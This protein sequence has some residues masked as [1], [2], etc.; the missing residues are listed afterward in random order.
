MLRDG[1][2]GDGN[3]ET[4]GKDGHE[5]P[6]L[7]L[8]NYI[9]YDEMLVSALVGLSGPTVFINDGGRYSLSK[10]FS[11]RCYIFRKDLIQIEPS[12]D[13]LE[14]SRKREFTPLLLVPGR[15]FSVI[16][17]AFSIFIFSS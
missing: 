7:T 4:I 15:F 6:P 11:Y 10:Y 3:F 17:T 16:W 1:R 5:L 2:R 13:S 14:R 9:S 12:Q 8:E